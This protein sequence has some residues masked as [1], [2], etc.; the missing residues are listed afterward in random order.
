MANKVD[1]VIDFLKEAYNHTY[2]S[3]DKYYFLHV[4]DILWDMKKC[5][6]FKD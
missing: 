1:E 2:S 5:G 3:E 4:I 6:K